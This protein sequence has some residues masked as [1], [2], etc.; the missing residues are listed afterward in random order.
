MEATDSRRTNRPISPKGKNPLLFGIFT[1]SRPW[2]VTYAEIWLQERLPQK[3]LCLTD[4]KQPQGLG[5]P[6]AP[7]QAVLQEFGTDRAM[8]YDLVAHMLD[9]EPDNNNVFS[10]IKAVTSAYTN[11]QNQMENTTNTSLQLLQQQT[12]S[13]PQGALLGNTVYGATGFITNCFSLVLIICSGNLRQH[14]R[15]NV[16]S[17]TFNDLVFMTSLLIYGLLS[18]TGHHQLV[19]VICWPIAYITLATFIVSYITIGHISIITYLAVFQPISFSKL[20]STRRILTAVACIWLSCWIVSLGCFRFDLPMQERGCS[21]IVLIPKD[22]LLVLITVSLLCSGIV[23]FL[24]VKTLLYF[25]VRKKVRVT[26]ISAHDVANRSQSFEFCKST[27]LSDSESS[28]SKAREN[29]T[30]LDSSRTQ[31]SI[32]VLAHSEK[33]NSVDDGKLTTEG[34][35]GTSYVSSSKQVNLI[36]AF[37]TAGSAARIGDTSMTFA[38]EQK[39]PCFAHSDMHQLQVPK[40]LFEANLYR[41]GHSKKVKKTLGARTSCKATGTKFILVKSYQAENNFKKCS[42][43]QHKSTTSTGVDRALS[44]HQKEV[45]ARHHV[46]ETG[47]NARVLSEGYRKRR[48]SS[49]S[50]VTRDVDVRDLAGASLREMNKRLHRATVTIVLLTL[51]CCVLTLPLIFYCLL[52]AVK[53]EKRMDLVYSFAGLLCKVAVGINILANPILYTW[54]LVHWGSVRSFIRNKCRAR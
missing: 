26:D 27:R 30:N 40:N 17:L 14:Q 6:E 35:T 44:D 38:T 47:M 10:L 22:G 28:S 45:F 1:R 20:V 8:F 32:K 36:K 37:E 18:T 42:K 51:T 15:I 49:S 12:S 13:I 52:L 11:I 4:Q 9:M 5:V 24:N 41:Q 3:L 50:I 33:V 25:H 43:R 16:L 46:P 21:P 29:H 2:I 54:R 7:E 53:P 31:N 23:I 39:R 34:S 19:R 48:S